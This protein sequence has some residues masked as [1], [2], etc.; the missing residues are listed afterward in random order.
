MFNV[1]QSVCIGHIPERLRKIEQRDHVNTHDIKLQ[2]D[3]VGFV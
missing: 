3:Q 2:A 1:V